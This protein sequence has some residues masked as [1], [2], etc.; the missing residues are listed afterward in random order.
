MAALV[1]KIRALFSSN[2]QEDIAPPNT[3]LPRQALPTRPP[4]ESSTSAIR[5]AERRKRLR[6]KM[7]GTDVP[8]AA[9][10]T[11]S[12]PVST[13]SHSP[14][15]MNFPADRSA[16]PT[17][18]RSSRSET[19]DANDKTLELL[20]LEEDAIK[21]LESGFDPYNTSDDNHATSVWDDD[22]NQR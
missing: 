1:E 4:E 14:A 16:D 19:G 21:R 3:Q 15:R 7:D 11:Q 18:D 2:E 10:A 5:M 22:I 8:S 12:E 17:P 9:P 6:A 13:Q 20:T